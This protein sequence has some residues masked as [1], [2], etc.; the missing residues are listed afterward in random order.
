[1][2]LFGG[3]ADAKSFV[4]QIAFEKKFGPNCTCG[5]AFL[6]ALFAAFSSFFAA[7]TAF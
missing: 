1:V 7:F 6:F 3:R 4:S 2:E 5:W